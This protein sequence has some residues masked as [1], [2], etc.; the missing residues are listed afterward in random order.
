MDWIRLTR[1]HGTGS[2]QVTFLEAHRHQAVRVHLD[3]VELPL[4]NDYGPYLLLWFMI[5]CP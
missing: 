5:Q 1:D 2:H 4:A 3:R